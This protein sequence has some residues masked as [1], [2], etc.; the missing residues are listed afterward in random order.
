MRFISERAVTIRATSMAVCF[1]SI[2]TVFAGCGGGEGDI[3]KVPL[4]PASGTVKLDGKPFGPVSLR[5]VPEETGARSFVCQVDDQGNINTVTT[6]ETGDGAP[7][8]TYKVT[9]FSSGGT[10]KKF[11]SI[12]EDENSTPLK[13]IIAD[14]QGVGANAMDIQLDSKAGG[15]KTGDSTMGHFDSETMDAAR[16]GAN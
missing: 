10:G 8:G 7:A 2:A 11:P 6:Y 1:V 3:V 12:Y 13:V 14:I 15:G 9:V 5:L 4:Y 16:A